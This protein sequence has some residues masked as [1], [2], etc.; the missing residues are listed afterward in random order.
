MLAI[1]VGWS[2]IYMVG[3][4]ICRAIAYQIVMYDNKRSK[5]HKDKRRKKYISIWN[6]FTRIMSTINALFVV[7]G[8]IYSIYVFGYSLSR[9]DFP[10]TNT[11]DM[12]F[13][14]LSIIVMFGY[15]IIDAV[16]IIT[17]NTESNQIFMVIHHFIGATG[18]YGFYYYNILPY[19]LLYY[20]LTEVTSITLNISWFFIKFEWNK[21][22][23]GSI[24]FIIFGALSWILWLVVRL[25]GVGFLAYFIYRDSDIIM[26]LSKE[27]IFMAYG[28]N[29]IIC[30]LNIFWFYKL[31]MKMLEVLY[32]KSEKLD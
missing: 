21:S 10:K 26:K 6:S 15:L 8:A 13:F 3:R 16:F 27:L 30:I 31:T 19:N 2:V 23:I 12:K 7:S 24:I 32:P 9:Y 18:L 20:Q 1:T 28:A 22:K 29:S 11:Q 4:D 25:F 14:Y 17:E 5:N